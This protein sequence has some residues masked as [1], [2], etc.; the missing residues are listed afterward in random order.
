MQLTFHAHVISKYSSAGQFNLLYAVPQT[1]CAR[2]QSRSCILSHELV[3][4]IE[5]INT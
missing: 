1:P 2:A 4:N 3:Y 5:T